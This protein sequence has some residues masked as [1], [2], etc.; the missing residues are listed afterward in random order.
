MFSYKIS[1]MGTKEGFYITTP[2]YYASGKPHIGHAFTTIYADVVARYQKSL[3]KDVFFVSGM[4]EHGQKIYEKALAE[5]K[6]TKDFVDEIAKDY[7]KVWDALNIQYDKFIRTTSETHKKGV[8]EFIETIHNTE[9]AVNKK[10]IYPD[11]YEGLYCVQCEK[12]YTEKELVRGLCPDHLSEPQK[13]RERNYFFNLKEFLPQIK[14]KIEN[15][16]LKI[17]PLAKKNEVLKMMDAGIPNFPI[18]R[19]KVVWGI[20]YPKDKNQTIYVWSDAL[21]SYLTALSYP[22]GAEYKRFWP[23]DLHIIGAEINKF[24][25][26][27][28]P[29]L[30]MSAKLPLPKE[31][32]VHGLFTVDGQKMSKTVG[33]VVDPLEIIKK[34]GADAAR[35]L[36]ISQFPATE[37]GDVK[38]SSFTKKYNTDLANGI[39]NLAERVFTMILNSG[40]HIKEKY[41]D[42]NFQADIHKIESAYNKYLEEY[43]LFEA[44]RTIFTFIKYLDRE[45]NEKK[46][47]SED[48]LSQ[49]TKKLFFVNLLFGV[50]K[51]FSW[52]EPFMPG[53]MSG[54]KNYAAKVRNKE[55]SPKEK[56]DLFPR[57]K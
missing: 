16:E 34:F 53:K 54:A 42:R 28:W 40:A 17:I 30:L 56:L 39:G 36:L 29:G 1:R 25:S 52:L 38:E 46:P 14:K 35:Y 20:P 31:I 32:F 7:E 26:I 18:T 9:N 15:D 5:H 19:E 55:I 37:H 6:A 44:L 12:F 23:A 13:I 43:N 21:V 3:G 8:L 45:I 24:H 50:E 10:Y 27:Y 33:N 4:D 41:I 22:D 2:I 47:W 11:F 57:I 51:I 48:L 49:A